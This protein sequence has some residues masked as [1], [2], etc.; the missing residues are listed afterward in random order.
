MAFD[1][2]LKIEGIDGEST[3]QQ[4]KGEIDV[5]SWSWGATQAIA[6]GGSGG[7]TTGKVSMQDFHFVSRVNKA[8]P[9]LFESCASGKHIDTATL[10]VRKA[11]D[12]AYDYIKIT[13]SSVLVSG[14]LPAGAPDD[15]ASEEV[16]LNFAKIEFEYVPQNA[17][18]SIASSVKTGYDV[19]ANKIA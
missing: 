11:G 2:F 6:S 18:G 3:D 13:L 4:H 14:Y 9:L 16:S 8:S 15:A 7:G 1:A 5:L 12:R 17:D 10:S 19:Q